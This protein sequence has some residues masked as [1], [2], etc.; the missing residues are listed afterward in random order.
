MLLACL[1]DDVDRSY[2][3]PWGLSTRLTGSLDNQV[4]SAEH[5][6]LKLPCNLLTR[7]QR[8]LLAFKFNRLLGSESDNLGYYLTRSSLVRCLGRIDHTQTTKRSASFPNS[9]PRILYD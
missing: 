8:H 4:Y 3:G 1:P 5:Y 2:A 7:S 9:Q 6:S